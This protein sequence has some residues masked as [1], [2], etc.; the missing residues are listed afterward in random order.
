MYTYTASYRTY[1]KYEAIYHGEFR[2]FKDCFLES[3]KPQFLSCVYTWGD[4][5]NKFG[6]NRTQDYESLTLP[7]INPHD[8]VNGYVENITVFSPW[9]K[10]SESFSV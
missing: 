4:T 8:A 9:I 3:K 6:G 10:I 7:H 5:V 1:I 2:R